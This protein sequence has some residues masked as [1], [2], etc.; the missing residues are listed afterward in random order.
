ME[1]YANTKIEI[2][3]LLFCLSNYS[4]IYEW[5]NIGAGW[6]FYEK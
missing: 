6:F 2:D 1:Y 4:T 3:M 5:W